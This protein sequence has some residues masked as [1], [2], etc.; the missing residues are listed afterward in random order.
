MATTFKNTT[1]T[2]IDVPLYDLHVGPGE[3]F[4]V[5]DEAA[6][7]FASNPWFTRSRTTHPDTVIDP[8]AIDANLTPAPADDLPGITT[9]A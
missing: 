1:D 2:P 4:E 3:T 8:A 6:D 9:T 7:S 5:P